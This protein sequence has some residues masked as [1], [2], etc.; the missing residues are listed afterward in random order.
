[1]K[2]WLFDQRYVGRMHSMIGLSIEPI[3][4]IFLL[5]SSPLVRRSHIDDA[6]DGVDPCSRSGFD[7]HTGG[8]TVQ[9]LW[10]GF[11]HPEVFPLGLG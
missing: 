8:A 11:R 6:V 9:Q 1:M 2:A 7:Q 5:P 10:A 4:H 3:S